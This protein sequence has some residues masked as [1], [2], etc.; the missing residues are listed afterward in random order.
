VNRITDL[1]TRSASRG[2]TCPFFDLVMLPNERYQASWDKL[3]GIEPAKERLLRFLMLLAWLGEAGVP[4]EDLALG[5]AVLLVGP[6]GTGKTT[7]ARACGHMLAVRSGK[8]A[9]LL[10]VRTHLLPSANKGGT[11]ANVLALFRAIREVAAAAR[12]VVVVFNE[13]ETAAGNR[14]EIDPSTNPMDSIYAVNAFIESWDALVRDH[15]NVVLLLTS[16]FP[17]LV[18]RAVLERCDVTM[19][20]DAPPLSAREAILR[21]AL[22]TVLKATRPDRDLPSNGIPAAANGRRKGHEATI[23]EVARRSEGMS[24]RELRKLVVRA[25]TFAEHPSQFRMD[26]LL[27]AVEDVISQRNHHHETGGEYAHAYN[28]KR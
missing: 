1:D 26:H 25:L 6:P 21:D 18:D 13:V 15:P 16:N 19:T 20:M 2:G 28:R 24:P 12:P 4:Y 17:R 7:M 3:I 11:Q 8:P 10:E 27:E 5:G 22:T 9:I 23:K 14:A